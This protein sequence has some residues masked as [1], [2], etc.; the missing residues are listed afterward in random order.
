MSYH[1]HNKG[2]LK[3]SFANLAK[4]APRVVPKFN[5]GCLMDIAT[6]Y[7]VRGLEN[8]TITNGG[9]NHFTGGTGEANSAKT[10]E[11]LYQCLTVLGRYKESSLTTLDTESTLTVDRIAN[12]ARLLCPDRVTT[13]IDDNG[14]E[15]YR[16]DRITITNSTQYSGEEFFHVFKNYG[17]E[18]SK[19]KKDYIETP[20]LDPDTNKIISLLAPDIVLVDSFSQLN[21][22]AMTEM[23]DK[24]AAGDP[25]QNMLWMT[26]GKVKSQILNEL[27]IISEKY[28]LY[29]Y[30]TTQ[31]G[32]NKEM[33]PYAPK[34]ST[35]SYLKGNLKIKK[36]PD[37]YRYNA[38][39]LWFNFKMKP[40]LNAAT[41][42]PEYP[43]GPNENSHK[44]SQDLQ[45]VVVINLR[46]KGG[47]SGE[48]MSLMY[49]QSSGILPSL[50]EFHYIKTN[51]Y[52]LV[53][54]D[55]NYALALYPEVSLSRTTIR[56]KL[57]A[58]SK[59]RVA[60]TLT[61]DLLQINTEWDEKIPSSLMCTP[62][63]LYED[64]KKLGYDWDV[65][66]QT[67]NYWTFD[68]YTN[69]IPFLSAMDLLYMREGSYVPYWLKDVKK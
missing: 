26:G 3:M 29:Y 39:N 43:R 4:A 25:K 37:E 16:L 13:Y 35:L 48:L 44:N 38:H 36:V 67:R 56:S 41:K 22:D 61:A 52:G 58:D 30:L 33:D 24:A 68:Q 54:N 6:G 21:V 32:E 14:I 19:L 47:K 53:G 10:G 49:S 46:N 51:K 63:I 66:L 50:T 23:Q 40:I 2:V 11:A 8:E 64:I 18:R 45:E 31:I 57:D 1:T 9:L 28:G 55:K 5:I 42:A 12:Q 69:P 60:T 7:P 17:K 20:F 65:L 27:P 34:R 15:Q 62:E 59:L